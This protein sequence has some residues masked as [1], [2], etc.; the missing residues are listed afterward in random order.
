MRGRCRAAI[1]R[2]RCRSRGRRRRRGAGCG[3]GNSLG[4]AGQQPGWGRGR[5][6]RGGAGRGEQ[7]L[8]VRGRRAEQRGAVLREVAGRAA[9]R[10]GPGAAGTPHLRR[11]VREAAAMAGRPFW[12]AGTP[13]KGGPRGREAVRLG[14][15]S[16]RGE[17]P[18]GAAGPGGRRV[19]VGDFPW[20]ARGVGRWAA[21][22]L[23]GEDL[24][25]RVGS[26]QG[27][28]GLKEPLEVPPRPA[29]SG[30]ESLQEHLHELD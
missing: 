28:W 4:G 19:P 23:G 8:G 18:A 14:L 24:P 5:R 6:G 3:P 21:G 26:G 29:G 2:R 13:R 20:G 7:K 27:R 15:R 12:G 9:G 10:R 17:D 11:W 16:G 22:G 1:G 30:D 25:R